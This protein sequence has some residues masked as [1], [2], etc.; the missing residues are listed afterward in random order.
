[1]ALKVCSELTGA[2]SRP[3]TVMVPLPVVMVMS[4]SQSGLPP[5]GVPWHPQPSA[6]TTSLVVF[7]LPSLQGVP[8][9]AGKAGLFGWQSLLL[10]TPSPSESPP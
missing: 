8:G 7:G 10:H 9:V 4:A 6:V 2:P 1:M 5:V 3:D